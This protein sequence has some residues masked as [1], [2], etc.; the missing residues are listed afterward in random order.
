MLDGVLDV[1]RWRSDQEAA[2]QRA[3]STY[4]SLLTQRLGQHLA[5]LDRDAPEVAAGIAD[6]L[7]QLDTA[8]LLEVLR[9]PE[10]TARLL[11]DHPGRCDDRVLSRYLVDVLDVQIAAAATGS[12]VGASSDTRW[13]ATG[14]LRLEPESLRPHS[15]IDVAGLP[16]DADSPAAICF[17]YTSLHGAGMRLRH[18]TDADAERLAIG[19]VGAAM[20]GI[21][22]VSDTIATY[23][24]RFTLV[25]NLIVDGQQEKFTSGSTGQ[26][27]GRSMFC[28]AHL[29]FVDPALLADGL[30]HEAVHSL[31]YMHEINERWVLQDELFSTNPVIASPWTG[32]VL[33]LRPF[34]QACFVWFA[35]GNFW[36]LACAGSG[37]DAHRAAEMRNA[38]Y[39]GFLGTR[40]TDR[41]GPYRD[42]IAGPVIEL[43]DSMNQQMI[44]N[45][46][47]AVPLSGERP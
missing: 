18:Y 34:L 20:A 19:R 36:S 43:I 9:A 5:S 16:I 13:S 31:L 6:R 10:T 4:T 33:P 37:F 47:E 12:A 39:Q 22:G 21:E 2:M 26:Y 32:T 11:W 14:V 23:V 27:I 45:A 7:A 8:D 35:L 28:N 24:R 17:D 3:E 38:A 40:L 1:L 46:G 15:L 25:A 29:P 30:V 44:D 41:L 42:Q